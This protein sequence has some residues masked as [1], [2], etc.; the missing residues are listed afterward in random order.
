LLAESTGKEGKGIIPITDEPLA[1][2]KYY[3]DDRLFVYLRVK[4]DDNVRTDEAEMRLEISGQPIIQLEINDQ[5]DL[6]GEFFRWEF[7][8][9]VAGAVLGI[10][11]FDQPNVQSTKDSTRQ[12]LK[13]FAS[14][15]KLPRIRSG[16]DPIKWLEKVKPGN[17]LA[18]MGYV[19]PTPSI[20]RAFSNFRS[21]IMKKYQISTTLGYGPR[22]LHSTGQ[23][24]K[25]G[26]NTGLFIQITAES[27]KDLKIPDKPYTF[28]ILTEAEAQGDYQALAAKGRKVVR[29]QLPEISGAAIERLMRELVP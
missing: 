10:N 9:A 26:P 17:Y 16:K 15:Q 28:G 18:I 19:K 7:A 2:P 21:R 20:D 29:I 23:L 11:P 24:H 3:G 13:E 27:R 6:G 12:V 22:F 25:G 8:T 1:A 14:S 4:G 5:Y